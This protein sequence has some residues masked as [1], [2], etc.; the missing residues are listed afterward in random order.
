M[1]AGLRNY[2]NLGRVDGRFS[3]ITTA[4]GSGL[5]LPRQIMPAEVPT[6]ANAF[7]TALARVGAKP[8]ESKVADVLGI[9][10]LDASAGGPVAEDAVIE[11]AND[12]G[13]GNSYSLDPKTYQSG[14]TWWSN[15]AIASPG[16]D[17]IGHITDAAFYSKEQGLEVS[18]ASTLKADSNV[19][20]VRSSALE[21]LVYEDLVA[22]KNFRKRRWE[23][24]SFFM[25][26][27]SLWLAIQLMKGVAVAGDGQPIF[28][29]DPQN[30]RLGALFGYPA[31]RCDGFD[32]FGGTNRVVGAVM[33]AR[34][35]SL[36]DVLPVSLTVYRNTMSRPNQTGFNLFAYHGF[37][38][39]PESVCKLVTPAS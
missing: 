37:G 10:V 30:D 25:L 27:E 15:K 7:R 32:A 1:N 9:P 20:V 19:G 35:F 21:G 2:I 16:F 8:I 28:M 18:I 12:P 22:L 39:A 3:T 13:I 33:T 14:T 29:R 34:G 11:T 38:W 36:R 26:G 17:V 6:H 24:G 31:V 23:E 5:L 4:S